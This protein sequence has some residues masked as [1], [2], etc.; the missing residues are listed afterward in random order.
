MSGAISRMG[1]YSKGTSSRGG[2][3]KVYTAGSLKHVEEKRKNIE[4]SAKKL[5]DK[6]KTLIYFDPNV[7]R[8]EWRNERL[9]R[10]LLASNFTT[11]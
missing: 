7:N 4:Y 3:T 5:L 11:N 1:A 8:D 6:T 9:L 10:Q 2:L